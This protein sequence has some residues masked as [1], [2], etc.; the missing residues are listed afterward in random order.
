MED[1]VAPLT[2]P[3]LR[4]RERLTPPSGPPV[5]V[6]C[7]EDYIYLVMTV[8]GRNGPCWL[9]V[10]T[11]EVAIG[12]VRD[13]RV[14]PWTVAHHSATGTVL[15]FRTHLDGEVGESVLLCDHLPPGPLALSAA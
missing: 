4:L 11:S 6:A 7:D 12:C 13:G 10:P 2:P 3:H 14:S 15:V 8:P 9:C 5:A 1:A